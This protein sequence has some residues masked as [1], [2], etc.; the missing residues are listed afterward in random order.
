[1][2]VL[3]AVAIMSV[4]TASCTGT[5]WADH[6][7]PTH[8]STPNDSHGPVVRLQL[9]PIPEGPTAPSFERDA[10]SGDRSVRPL[11]QVQEYLPVPF[12]PPLEQPENCN[13]GGNLVVT[14]ADGFEFTYGPCKRP[15]SINRLW[16]GMVYVV[17][18]GQCAP[19]CG[20]GGSAG[21]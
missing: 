8:T 14:F 20:P 2:K 15:S 19:T 12:P 21:P 17:D 7:L 5:P 3:A 9:I 16:A 11:K 6:P 1:M 18:D 13:M 4:V 10:P